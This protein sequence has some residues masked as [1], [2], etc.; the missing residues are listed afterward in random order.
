MIV[1][2]GET[3][4]EEGKDTLVIVVARRDGNRIRTRTMVQ[5]GVGGAVHHLSMG[6]AIRPFRVGRDINPTKVRVTIF[7]RVGMAGRKE[8][9]PEVR[10]HTCTCS[11]WV[12]PPCH[13]WSVSFACHFSAAVVSSFIIPSVPHTITT[14]S[15]VIS[16]SLFP[17]SSESSSSRLTA[18]LLNKLR[19]RLAEELMKG[20]RAEGNFMVTG[21]D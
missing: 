17:Q 3:N 5:S 21:G 4:L 11:G 10:R 16:N 6:G 1:T 8:T 2:V 18:N 9:G 13:A 14:S 20:Q 12:L 7:L 19:R 15:F